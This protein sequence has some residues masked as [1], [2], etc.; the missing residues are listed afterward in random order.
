M[1]VLGG[2][3]WE[4]GSGSGSGG[5]ER[6]ERGGEGRGGEG[7]RGGQAQSGRSGLRVVV[8]SKQALAGWRFLQH[9]LSQVTAMIL[10]APFEIAPHRISS[11]PKDTV[12]T[13]RIVHP[14]T[15]LQDASDDSQTFRYYPS[16]HSTIPDFQLLT[17]VFSPPP[18]D[19][20]HT[21][22]Q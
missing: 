15:L 3:R 1:R 16:P 19:L 12:P 4:E 7:R 6:G 2:Q 5:E 11:T 17:R 18:S 8:P 22:P 20:L 9:S 13:R 21:S 14:C 10:T